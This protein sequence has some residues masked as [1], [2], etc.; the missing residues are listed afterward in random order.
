MFQDIKISPSILSADFLAMGQDIDEI[1]DGGADWIHIDV[2]DGHFVPNLT[3]G[4][5]LVSALRKTGNRFL[6]V[7]LMIDNPIEQLPWYLEHDPD[8]VTVHLESFSDSS[9]IG[10]A[11]DL[12]EGAGALSGLAVKP[13][14]PIDSL[15]PWVSRLDMVLVMSVFPGFS[16]QSFIPETLERLDRLVSLCRSLECAPLIQ[17]DGGIDG[18]TARSVASRGAD[19]LVAGSGVFGSPDRQKAI[20]TIRS[21]ALEAQGSEVL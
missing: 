1:V 15:K 13:D 5:P 19:V 12:I 6:D 10:R 14:T 16:G 17:V 21:N 8:M 11:L 2:M 20:A 9:G 3:I 18:E 4:V 7:H